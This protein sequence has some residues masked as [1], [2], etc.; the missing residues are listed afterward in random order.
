MNC[1]IW[2]TTKGA[3]L[4]IS[5]LTGEYRMKRNQRPVFFD[6]SGKRWKKT[7]FFFAVIVSTISIAV[8]VLVPP[9]IASVPL[10]ALNGG[11]GSSSSPQGMSLQ[12][13][14]DAI[15]AHN[16]PVIG[17]GQLI[18]VD[19]VD[20]QQLYDIF[21]DAPI[22]K[23]TAGE[24]MSA[25]KSQ[26]VIER[27]GAPHGKQ[28]A[29]T[30]DDGPDPRNTGKILDTLSHNSVPATFFVVG[31]NA[32]KY[33]DLT[34]RIARE[35]H[36]IGNHTFTHIDIDYN[37]PFMAAQEINQTERVLRA[38]TGHA[39]SFIR[40]PY[41]GST[42]QALRDSIAGI[43]LGQKLG[44]INVGYDYD[45]R[46]W[47]F[48]TAPKPSASVFDGTSKI[49][50]LHDGGGDRQPTVEY[51][52]QFIAMGKAAGYSFVSINQLY[53]QT[54][55]L[56]G[57]VQPSVADYSSL[58]VAQAVLVW[59]S[60]TIL[61]LFGVTVVLLVLS[62]VSNI[63]LAT[64]QR[65]RSRRVPHLSRQYRPLVSVI[66]PAHNEEKVL[67]PA[68]KSLFKSTY[69]KIEVII[70]NDGSTDGTLDVAR[71]LEASYKRLRVI[72]QRGRGKAAALNHAMYRSKG[73][74]IVCMDADTILQPV[75]ISR[76]VRHFRNPKVGAVAGYVKVGNIRNTLS[77]WQALEYATSIA[78]ERNAQAY[79][80]AVTVV[81]GACG[82]W[83]KE[84]IVA[85][86]GFAG[87]T[88]AEDC[89]TA[90]AVHRAGYTIAQ[91][92]AAISLTECPLSFH[93][94]AKQRFRWT[95]GNIQSY[96]KHR[97]LFFNPKYG[98]LGMVVL[99]NA[100]LS[101]LLPLIFWPLLLSLTIE[102]IAAGRFTTMLLFFAAGSALQTIVAF[103]GLRLAREKL[104]Y[105]LVLPMTRLMY[106]PLRTYLLFRSAFTMLRGVYVGWNK[107]ARTATVQ[108]SQ[109]FQ[110]ARTSAR[111]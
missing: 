98:W 64:L 38:M 10:A 108:H 50:L 4:T 47:Q 60:K 26:Y 20:N 100:A 1:R 33:A 5:Y 54:P 75:T 44:Y 89:D 24:K 66:V 72:N 46:D 52:K 40:I 93:D 53:E 2:Y 96:W 3:S 78:I 49:V 63:T 31:Q 84:A 104:R 88:L 71:T 111:R 16:T 85:A 101:V 102:N 87:H 95:F 94:L 77:M 110:V 9:M 32:V 90:L 81:P 62:A 42:D 65:R 35:G 107:L 68:I 97:R 57:P 6:A 82:A 27:Y 19:R 22:R 91:D 83:R 7:K 55:A 79:L 25:N 103:I 37:A 11:S 67:I 109:S 59:P 70:V 23:L 18:R 15:N 17:S 58:A 28:I 36:T 14:I 73:E 86:K 34:Q 45:T 74:I 61:V 41:A 29:L 48:K 56:Y 8:V 106:G 105:L 43:L 39:S 80:G 76:L 51:L 13:A 21:T 12:A 99:P 30:F 69:R 92:N